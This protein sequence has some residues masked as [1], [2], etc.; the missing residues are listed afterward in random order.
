MNI[1]YLAY[2][3]A[4]DALTQAV[5]YPRLE[6]LSR[7]AAVKQIIF[8]TIERGEMVKPLFSNP[9]VEWVGF[10]SKNKGNILLT[11]SADFVGLPALL[12]KIVKEKKI[13]LV[14]AN[15]SLAGGMAYQVWRSTQVPFLV[16]CFEPHADY[17]LESGVW[18]IWHMRYWILRYFEYQQKKHAWRLLTV[19][20]HYSSKL[21]HD[22]VMAKKIRTLPNC[23]N[24]IDF[25]FKPGDREAVRRR[26]AFSSH[27]RIGIYVGKFGGL[28]YIEEAYELFAQAFKFFGEDF[29]MIILTDEDQTVV[30]QFL[31]VYGIDL[32]KVLI[33]YVPH[34]EVSSH[35]SAADFAFATI[36]PTASALYRCLVKN[37]E[38]WA[39]GLPILLEEGVGNDSDLVRSEGGGVL[40]ALKDP[41]SGFTQLSKLLERGREQLALEI[42]PIA[43]RH[44]R[45]ELTREIFQEILA[46]L[47]KKD[48]E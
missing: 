21:V 22:G 34:H 46:D 2:W 31:T 13:D 17:M 36:K 23:V 1:L 27:H 14:I 29:R 6:I 19:A 24:T 43:Y 33:A 5:I 7:E 11:K 35:L 18:K 25:E 20:Q 48:A 10:N 41:T 38:Y 4:V 45:M 26:L 44:R 15:S 39:N 9:K 42:A 8:C 37:G 30:R 40:F 16:E 12:K 47:Y 28:Y 32:R 3:P